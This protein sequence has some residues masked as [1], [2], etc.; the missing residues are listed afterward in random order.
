MNQHSSTLT[1]N[2]GARPCQVLAR[3]A[4]LLGLG[5]L[6][7][8]SAALTQAQAQA[9]TQAQAQAPWPQKTI[10]LWVG[11]APGGPTDM[12]ARTFA[13]PLSA[14]LGQQVIVDNK[15]GAGGALAANFV[16]KSAADG[17]TLLLGEPGSISINAAQ[18]R[19]PLYDPLKEFTAVS[20]VVSLPMVLA[21]TPSLKV[22]SLQELM[23][24]AKTKPLAYG[25]PGNGTMQHLTLTQFG[26]STHLE[27]IHV[28]YKGGAP[29]VTDLLGG[30][31]PLVMVTVPSIAPYVKTGAIVPLAVVAASRSAV[32]PQVPTFSESGYPDFIQDGWQGFFG[33][34][35]LPK[36]VVGKLSSA[37]LKVGKD[38]QLQSAMTAIGANVVLSSSADFAR[39]VQRDHAHWSKLVADNPT[40]KD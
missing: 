35:P 23:A 27:F 33:P 28:A 15:P 10:H 3:Q 34:A 9:Q 2:T 29:A 38:P 32:L 37:I 5:A 1:P 19:G 36:E 20:Q 31:I 17:Y 40:A 12:V 26:Q 21:A 14:Q 30:Q 22:N 7:M 11:F 16:A 39:V 24:L 25:T 18:T 8:G 4:K 6:F 13:N